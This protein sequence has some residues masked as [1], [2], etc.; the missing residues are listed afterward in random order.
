MEEIWNH[1]FTN[2]AGARYGNLQV[3]SYH[4]K[5]KDSQT[6]WLCLCDCGNEIVVRRTGLASGTIS[7][8]CAR[9]GAQKKTMVFSEEE[10]YTYETWYNMK[11]RCYD[12]NFKHYSY[13]G[14]SGVTVCDR[15]LEPDGKGFRNFLEDM[16]ERPKDMS[17]NRI[18]S[19]NLYS[20][21]TCEWADKQ[22]QAFDQKKRK[23]NTSGKT[24]VSWDKRRQKWVATIDFNKPIYLGAFVNIEDA[25][26]ARESAEMK[27][28]GFTKE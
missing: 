2:L 13:Y 8:G 21:E 25:I 26:A 11:R 24:G 28:H 19:V 6:R 27:Y 12:L 5:T 16:G 17:L 7:C 1:R 14:G 18:N 4:S 15:W 9:K 10:S 23:N 22:S 3:L 20:K